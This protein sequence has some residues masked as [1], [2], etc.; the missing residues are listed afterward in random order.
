MNGRIVVHPERNRTLFVL[1]LLASTL[2]VS[3]PAVNAQQRDFLTT[4]EVEQVRLTQEPNE[5]MV[6]YSKFAETRIGQIRDLLRKDSPGRSLLVHDLLGDLIEI[7]D[8][9]DIVADD[10]LKNG[11]DVSEGMQKVLE[12]HQRIATSLG[13]VDGMKLRDRSRYQFQLQM[14]MD[15]I[16]DAIALA[17]EDLDARKDD[18]L[19]KEQQERMRREE[20]R[21]P[22]DVAEQKEEARKQAEY[23]RKTGR[24]RKPPTLFKPGEKEKE[25]TIGSPN[26]PRPQ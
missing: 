19:A 10:A 25:S 26:R 13:E 11:L 22:K 9:I 6:L 23:D 12:E 17:Q 2:L 14:A 3:S 20:V 5:R 7:I 21:T 4:D 16:T 15:T 8:T 1:L 24:S 18:V